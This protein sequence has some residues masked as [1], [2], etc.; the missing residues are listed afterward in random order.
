MV[1]GAKHDV[2]RCSSCGVVDDGRNLTAIFL[3]YRNL[4]FL[5]RARLAFEGQQRARS[6]S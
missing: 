1:A 5:A 3:Q 6:L 4:L 2:S